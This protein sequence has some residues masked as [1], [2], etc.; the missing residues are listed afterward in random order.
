MIHSCPKI[1]CS[2][3]QKTTQVVR[4]GFYFRKDDSRKI[5]RYQCKAC[6]KKFSASTSTLEWKQKKRRLNHPLYQLFSSGISQRRAAIILNLHKTTIARKL[7][8]LAKKADLEQKDLLRKLELNPVTHLQFDDLITSEH[9]KLKP[10]SVSIAV[11]AKRRFILG[12]KVSTIGSFGHLSRL[13]KLKYG[14]RKNTHLEKLKELFKEIR[15][16]LKDNLLIESDDHKRYPEV[17]KEFCPYSNHLTYKGK[18]A[19]V[20]GQ[21]ELKKIIYDPLF[22]INHTCA[23]LRANVNRIFRRTWC[24]TKKKEKLELHLKI[25]AQFY[26]QIILQEQFANLK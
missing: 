12:M 18:R 14:K 13:S 23:M 7:D 25:F 10:L 24:T 5:A 22:K 9:T 3:Y 16:V 1:S 8:Y 2:F 15:P 11:D 21:G 6:L 4:D 26:N 19:T 20:A 17:V